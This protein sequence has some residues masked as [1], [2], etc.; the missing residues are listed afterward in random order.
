MKL[1]W[2]NRDGKRTTLP[3][4]R[5]EQV[6]INVGL[7]CGVIVLHKTEPDTAKG[8]PCPSTLVHG[9]GRRIKGEGYSDTYESDVRCCNCGSPR[10]TL[11][12]KMSTLF[13]LREDE[14]VLRSG[15]VVL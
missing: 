9:T 13:G 4:P 5:G 2:I 1:T 12:A 10:G 6:A 14:N 15:Y 7:P 3:T 11:E 8:A